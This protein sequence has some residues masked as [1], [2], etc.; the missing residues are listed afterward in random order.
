MRHLDEKS[1]LGLYVDERLS[2]KRICGRFGCHRDV[3]R[4]ILRKHR[5]PIRGSTVAFKP[6]HTVEPFDEQQIV[7]RYVEDFVSVE[8]LAE[9]YGCTVY[10]IDQI[11]H[12]HQVPM[13]KKA[14]YARHR[15]QQNRARSPTAAPPPAV[16]H[17]A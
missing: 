16:H 9:M 10:R 17:A 8:S 5:I 4:R 11:L 3:I 14:D 15:R 6:D 1:V 12:R 2:L 7:R 13:R